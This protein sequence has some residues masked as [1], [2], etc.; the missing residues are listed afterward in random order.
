[1]N[2]DQPCQHCGKFCIMG[3]HGGFVAK[4]DAI[5]FLC[6]GCKTTEQRT[7]VTCSCCGEQFG[8]YIF[9]GMTDNGE[10]S[11]GIIVIDVTKDGNELSFMIYFYTCKTMACR[12]VRSLQSTRDKIISMLE[13][14]LSDDV[15]IG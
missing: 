5:D 9:D 4:K 14:R 11:M 8:P 7:N 3:P 12:S 13:I 6:F 10:V 15:W 2:F 1:M